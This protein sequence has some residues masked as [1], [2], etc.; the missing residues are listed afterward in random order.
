MRRRDFITLLG[1]AAAT[2]PLA[3]RAQ[4]PA[5]PVIGFLNTASRA[6][7]PPMD[8]FR[9]GLKTEGYVEG[10][11]VEMDSRWANWDLAELPALAADLVQRRVAVI[12]ATGGPAAALAAKRATSTIPIVFTGGDDPVEVGLTASLNRPGGNATGVIYVSSRLGGKR[13]SLLGE[14][15]PQIKTVGFLSEDLN[16]LRIQ[17]QKSEFLAAAASTGRQP[18]VSEIRSG[19]DIDIAFSTLVEH[20]VE[21]LVVGVNTIARRNLDEIVALA[22]RHM[23]PTIYPFRAYVLSGGLMSYGGSVEAAYYPAGVY[24]GRILKGANPADLPVQ[25]STRFELAI[26]LKT[27]KTLGLT[28]SRSL[29]AGADEVIE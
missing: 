15:A 24:V 4:Q 5:M 3:A 19:D 23:I 9:R 18:I 13:L 10:Q 27:A 1:S 16:L 26:N 12:V 29:L 7:S 8:E 17:Q 25:Q 11:N 20:H 6:T 21:A 14:M 22:A 2:W 28:V